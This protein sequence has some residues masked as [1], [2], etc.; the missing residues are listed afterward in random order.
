MK[1]NANR[2]LAA[3]AALATA[4][5]CTA[6]GLAAEAAYG[7][8]GNGKAIMEYLDRGIYA[9]KSGGG[10][11]VSWRYNADD[12]D[13]AEFRLYRDNTLIY[14]SKK[15]DPTSFQDNGGGTGSKYRVDCV[16]GGKVTSSQN[17]KFTSGSNYFDIKLNRPGSQY[18]PND[19]SV[20]DVDGD[21][22]YEIF[23]KW[24]PS[25]SKD[26][27]QQGK[28]DKVYIDCYTLEGKQLWRIDMG[29]NIRAG[30][31]YTQMC[32]ADFD[33]DGKAELITKTADGTKDGTGKTIG[34]GS[35]NYVNG[36]GYILDGPEYLSL[37]DGMTGKCLDTIDFPVPRGKVS[38][39]G[40][41]YGNRVDRMNSGI[42]YLDGEHPSAVY[43]RGYYTRLTWSAVDVR[44]GKLVKRWVYDSGNKGGAYGNGNHNVMAADVDNDGKQELLTGAACIDDNGKLL[45]CS[46]DKH[47]DAMHVGDLVPDNEG[48]EVWECH[49]DKPYGETCY[50]AKTGKRLFHITGSKDTGRAC[51]DNVW[52]GNK[53]AEFWGAAD[54]NVYDKSG[55]KI[56][57]SKPAQNFLIYWD[58]DLEREIL[59]GTKITKMTGAGTYKGIFTASGCGSNNSTKN[60]P[61]LTADLFGDWREELILRTDDNSKLRIWCTTDTTKVRLTTLMHDMQYRAQNACEQSCYNQPPHV[62]YYLG[63]DAPIPARPNIL[64]NNTPNRSDTPAEPAETPTEYQQ[65]PT[66]NNSQ[67]ATEAPAQST[68][69]YSRKFDLGANAQS[70][71]TGVSAGDRYDSGKG[72]GFSGGDVK[73]VSASGRNELSDAVQFTGNTTFNADVPNGLYKVKVTLG[74]TARTSVYMENMLQIVNMT[75][76]NA[77]DEIILP[78]TDGQLNIRAAAGK[79]GNPYSIS[80]VEINK[81]SDSTVMPSTIWLCGDSTVCNYYPLDSNNQAGWGQML[82]KYVDSSWY[83]RNMAASGEYAK[84]FVD[85][86]NFTCIEKYGKSGDVFVISIGINDSKYY[87]GDEYKKVVT[88]MVKRAKAK[89]MEV[90]LV[91]Q[92]GRKGDSSLNPLLKSRYFSAQL[93]QIASEQNCQ[94]VDLFT[95]WQDYCVS[96]GASKADSMYIDNVHP[97]R[98]GADKLA[99]LFASKFG[100]T[101]SQPSAPVEQ[102]T[103]APA[104][105]AVTDGRLI[106]SLRVN[107][108]ATRNDWSVI[109]S[110]STGSPVFGDRDFTYTSLPSVLSGAEAVKTACNSKNSTGDLGQ[111][112]AGADIDVYI[113]LDQRVEAAGNIPGW[114]NSWQKTGLTAAT[115]NDVTFDLYKKTFRSGE[116]VLLGTNGM[117]GNV[118]NY[119]V[120]AK[121]AEQQS[122]Q[123]A[124]PQQTEAA[125]PGGTYLAGD[126]N[127]DGRID[128]SDAVAILQ[129]IANSTKYALTPQGIANADVSGHGDGITGSDAA[130]IQKYDASVITSLPEN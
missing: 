78:V 36:N 48:I 46:G 77:V 129:Y 116:T 112:T 19:C 62:S 50:D 37:F 87:N 126:A 21:G 81:I 115:S 123:P 60:N 82:G 130:A 3:A 42:A 67:P 44:G 76:D 53:G 4:A 47:G 85:R 61:S 23:L 117:T 70:G 97:N 100:K 5:G 40:D 14:T 9:V 113:L 111:F 128:I 72:Y 71:F 91:K 64:L 105:P 93:D 121:D 12:S 102:S 106:K 41:N 39:W 18:S 103:Q 104:Q 29:Q 13:D 30:Q 51:A 52:S 32:V 43:G 118:I 125:Q 96:V 68:G 56:A 11:F 98:T 119:T 2:V 120:F 80:A 26:N 28:T 49:E 79:E 31:H 35:K 88:D 1:R 124:Q 38:D 74:N 58:G 20:G 54:N 75:G 94:I 27:S 24:D 95:L 55:K 122:V 34:N 89:G 33:C 57:G 65:A 25:N 17:C 101:A 107:D 110:A 15:G 66:E 16:E 109:S 45:W 127:C 114:I 84:G 10:M 86:G 8:G 6:T 7:V 22:Q 69:S 73:N 83:I 90:I 99:E 92:Q 108:D 59:D 63:S